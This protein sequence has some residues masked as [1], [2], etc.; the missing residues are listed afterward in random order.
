MFNAELRAKL[1]RERTKIADL[2]V[3]QFRAL[4]Q[5]CFDADRRVQIERRN[6]EYAA[7]QM[8]FAQNVGLAPYSANRFGAATKQSVTK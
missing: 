2:T 5:D 3:E 6:A 4:M 1:R 7:R 8:L